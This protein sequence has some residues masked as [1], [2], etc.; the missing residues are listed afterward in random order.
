MI[1]YTDG[2]YPKSGK[3]KKQSHQDKKEAENVEEQI[4]NP[5]PPLFCSILLMNI[6]SAVLIRTSRADQK[7]G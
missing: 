1:I 3:T 7:L 5:F 4:D 6:L 2:F